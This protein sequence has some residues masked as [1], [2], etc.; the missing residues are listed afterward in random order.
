MEK[1]KKFHRFTFYLGF[2]NFCAMLYTLHCIHYWDDFRTKEVNIKVKNNLH[3][4][5][6]WSEGHFQ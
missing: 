5:N 4:V 2:D 3:N 1:L 6:K